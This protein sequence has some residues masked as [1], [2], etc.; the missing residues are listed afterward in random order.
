[1][2]LLTKRWLKQII[3]IDCESE[4]KI[5]IMCNQDN[6]YEILWVPPHCPYHVY[7]YICPEL[8][9]CVTKFIHIDTYL[10]IVPICDTIRAKTII[11]G[12]TSILTPT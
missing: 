4:P 10:Q 8:T 7:S 12:V 9:L 1:M 2:S 11:S 6:T 3:N 5:F